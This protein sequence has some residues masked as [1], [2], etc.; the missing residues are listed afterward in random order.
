[1]ITSSG[2]ICDVCGKYILPLDPEERVN[3]FS[4]E[5][6][7]RLLHCHNA[8]KEKVLLAGSDWHLLPPGPLREAFEKVAAE[9]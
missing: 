9:E 4:V 2:A 5:G 7:N 3:T 1:M 6:A 8:C